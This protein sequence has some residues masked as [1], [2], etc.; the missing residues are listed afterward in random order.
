MGVSRAD[1]ASG[2]GL[3]GEGRNGGTH[4]AGGEG[5]KSRL[6]GDL[7]GGFGA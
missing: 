3:G 1:Y 6:P 4:G 7:E 5:R 2:E